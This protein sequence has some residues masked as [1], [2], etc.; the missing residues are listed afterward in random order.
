MTIK[1]NLDTPTTREY[2]LSFTPFAAS[3]LL[4]AALC[5]LSTA[6]CRIAISSTEPPSDPAPRDNPEIIHGRDINPTNTG[7]PVGQQL[8]SVT[9]S[10]RVTESWL[11]SHNNGS[12]IIENRLFVSGAGLTIEAGNITVR[13]CLFIGEGRVDLPVAVDGIVIHD[14]EFDGNQENGGSSQAIK[15]SAAG[16]HLLRLYVHHWPR[17]LTVVK[18]RTVVENCCLRDLTS[19]DSEAHIENIYVAGGADMAFTGNWMEANPVSINPNQDDY[20]IS[21]SLAI[22]NQGGDYQDLERIVVERN[23]FTGIG[24]YAFYGGAASPKSGPYAKD[25]T[26]RGNVFG[27]EY[28]RKGGLFG[29]VTAFDEKTSGNLWAD[30]TWGP[31]GPY[32]VA[33]DPEEGDFI[34]PPPVTPR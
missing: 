4:A 23:Y 15:N 3:S 26:V 31:R 24:S 33:G 16:L 27:R 29:P 25:I 22:Y 30:N 2:K 20:A 9:E 12:R 11:R 18:G 5:L 8:V 13:Y 1:T 28:M 34:N 32:W 19:D 21:A 10:I 7:V 6:G 17:A 14:C